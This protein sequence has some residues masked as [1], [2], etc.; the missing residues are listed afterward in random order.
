VDGK[1][2]DPAWQTAGSQPLLGSARR[3]NPVDPGRIQM[4]TDGKRLFLAARLVD[5]AG[6][7]Y[8]GRAGTSKSA[9][10][11]V[12]SGEHLRIEIH[13]GQHAHIWALSPEQIPYY[14][15]DGKDAVSPWQAVA[16]RC[17]THWIAEMAIP[18]HHFADTSKLRINVVHR[19]KNPIKGLTLKATYTEFELRPTFGLGNHP[20]L[21]PDWKA[22][23]SPERFAA[24]HL[25]QP[26]SSPAAK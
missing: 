26:D 2:D 20:D 12:L 23:S 11:L 25:E 15:L 16:G 9:S 13:D 18:L 1:L 19:S 7:V 24:L 21:I 6:Q 22:V 17:Q 4:A 8:V 5:P 10:K 3:E 14:S